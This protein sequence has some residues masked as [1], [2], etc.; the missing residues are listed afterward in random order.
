MTEPDRPLQAMSDPEP[1]TRQ[2][3]V[4]STVKLSWADVEEQFDSMF[5][6]FEAKLMMGVP[7]PP[8]EW[9]T[10]KKTRRPLQAATEAD[11]LLQTT[12]PFTSLD[13]SVAR[14]PSPSVLRPARRPS[15]ARVQPLLRCSSE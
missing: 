11:T 4:V 1:L 15:T 5:G 9:I 14:S 2:N 8:E 10:P 3:A 6:D 12:N 7:P 13:E